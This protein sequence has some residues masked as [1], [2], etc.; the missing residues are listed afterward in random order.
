MKE[1]LNI[2]FDETSYLTGYRWI[3][4]NV[5][6]KGTVQIAHG[7]S[8]HVARYDAFARFLNDNGYTVIA[9]DHYHHGESVEDQKDLGIIEQY[10]FIE[11][12]V[13]GLKLVR[14]HFKEDF[15]KKNILF[16]HSM[17]SI[18]SQTY[19]QRYPYDFDKLILSGTDIGD[20]RYALLGLLTAISVRKKDARTST[21]LIHNLTFG[22]FQKKFPEPSPFNWLSKNPENIKNYELDPLC[23]APVSDQTYHSISKALR[24]SFKL[25]NIKKINSQLS[26]FIFSGAEDPVSG[27]GKSVSKLYRKYKKANLNV[28][29]KLYPTLRHETLNEVEFQTIFDDVLTFIQQ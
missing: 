8:E 1:R 6:H 19:I 3:N 11:A 5:E 17:G 14:E 12:V 15:D 2:K 10:D 4:P 7:L 23:G 28:V 26:I 25:K 9:F 13:T 18:S 16:S 24:Q 21:K 22:N 29:M 20:I 27:F